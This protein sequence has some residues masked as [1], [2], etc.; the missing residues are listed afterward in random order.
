[1]VAAPLLHTTTLLLFPL[2]LAAVPSTRITGASRSARNSL[3]CSCLLFDENS[4]HSPLIIP[5]EGESAPSVTSWT[6]RAVFSRDTLR[7]LLR[8]KRALSWRRHNS[9][10]PSLRI[11]TQNVRSFPSFCHRILR[12]SIR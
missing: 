7:L 11:G 3:S 10:H 5:T 8:R 6:N 12:R 4:R 2:T 1:M 9:S